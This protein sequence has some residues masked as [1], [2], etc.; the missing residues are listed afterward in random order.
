MKRLLNRKT[1]YPMLQLILGYN[2]NEKVCSVLTM[3]HLL[4]NASL[5]A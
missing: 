4:N 1:V 5:L 2:I 3:T